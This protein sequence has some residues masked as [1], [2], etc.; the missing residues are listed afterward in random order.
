MTERKLLLTSAG[1]TNE[2]IREALVDLLGKPI[3]QSTALFVPTAIYAYPTGS[4]YAWTSLQSLGNLGWKELG[5]LELTALPSVKREVWLPE[6]EEA[7]AIIV[8]GGNAFYL[9]FW[10]QESGLFNV[11]SELLET[12]KTYVGISAGSMILTHS[13][14]FDRKRFEKTGIYYDDEYEE[15]APINAGS[16]KTMHLVGFVIRPHLNLSMA[17]KVTLE[18][19]EKWAAKIDVP[20]YAIDDQTA[21]KVIDGKVEVITE[22][23]WKLFE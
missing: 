13:L 1:I 16:D 21:L 18:N 7:D 23:N 11:L 6:V 3:G 14:N 5:I 2:R 19:I 10:M 8:G 22:G 15:E 12:G 17:P 9:S 20:L 4:N